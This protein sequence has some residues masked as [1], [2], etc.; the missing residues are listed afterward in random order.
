M[1]SLR[2]DVLCNYTKATPSSRNTIE[3]QGVI[4]S[5]MIVMCGATVKTNDK[6]E[7]YALCLQTSA[8]TSDPHII[9]GTLIIK[10]V[11]NTDETEN[12][13]SCKCTVLAKSD[14]AKVVNMLGR[15]GY[16]ATGRNLRLMFFSQKN[17]QITI[18]NCR[19]DLTS[20][21]FVSFTD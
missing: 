3:G 21:E 11:S 18:V 19:H 1:L 4:N 8:L 7:L 6:I 17:C 13:T 9:T 15:F 2:L 5:G 10:N 12:L 14:Q 20:L 16:F